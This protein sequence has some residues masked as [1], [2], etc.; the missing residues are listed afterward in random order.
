M[1]EETAGE[2]DEEGFDPAV[3]VRNYDEV[4]RSLPVF[5][6]SSRG[7]QKLCGC[8]KKN[9]KVPGFT[10][11]EQPEIPAPLAHRKQLTISGGDAACKLFITTLSQLLDS[12]TSWASADGTGTHLAAKQREKEARLLTNSLKSLE[13]VSGPQ[14]LY[15]RLWFPWSISIPKSRQLYRKFPDI[16]NKKC[17]S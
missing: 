3:D 10:A 13:I 9:P 17:L 4:A 16:L 11:I 15:D 8:L 2:A 5:C 14:Q 7:Y 12:L 1:D 6:V